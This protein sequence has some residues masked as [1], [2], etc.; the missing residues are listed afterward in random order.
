[1]TWWRVEGGAIDPE[2][3][4]GISAAVADPLWLLARQWQVGEFRGEDAASPVLIEGTVEAAPITE[5]WVERGKQRRTVGRGANPWPL[6]TLVEHEPIAEGP[7]SA[8]VRLEGGAE[9][10]RRLV[11]ARAPVDPVLD[12]FREAYAFIDELDAE[13]D[14]VGHAR[15]VLL[16]RRV[17]DASRVADAVQSA[18]GD[19]ARLAQLTG[20]DETLAD[21]LAAVVTD[22]LADESAMFCDVAPDTLTA[23]VTPRL[24]Y[25]FGVSAAISSG[26]IE[27]EAEEYPGGRLD[28][29]HFDVRPAP[30]AP[31][32]PKSGRDPVGGRIPVPGEIEDPKPVPGLESKA[33]SSLAS[34]LTFAGMPASRWWEFEDHDVDFGDLA[35]GPDDLARS[36]IAAYSMVAGDDWFVVPCTLTAGSLAQVRTMRVLDDFG[37]S[38][39]ISATAVGDQQSGSRPWRFFELSGDPG[40]GRDEAPMLFLLPVLAGVE[41][42][43]PLESVAFRRDEMANLAWAI[44]Q[45]VE[46]EAGRAVDREAG[47]PAVNGHKVEGD[48]W[49][50]RLST[51][52]PDH[53]VPLVPVRINGQ[54]PQIA[55]RR[56]RIA[57][58]GDEQPA[59]GRILEPEHPF[60]M[61][62]EEIPFGGVRV[63][64]RYQVARG[65]DG[66][67]RAWVGR[68]KAPAGGP[69]R[70]TP[71]RFDELI[72]W[73]R[74][75]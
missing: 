29:F 42:G 75:A 71:L 12:G 5:Y 2:L 8:R 21:A 45:R 56:G 33:L 28:W 15:L 69:L 63:T 36:V 43:R 38:T 19:P 35:G 54:N 11:A 60:V 55:L 27:L 64:R 17:P 53:W 3:T 26:T 51:D 49:R 68:H 16:A 50:Y 40:P 32:D 52:V 20:L 70:R 41:Q 66:K 30:D 13:L 22:W 47:G 48:D 44:E 9:L 58:E 4:E 65:A 31:K 67:V 18:G 34:P 74:R 25:S 61:H 62:E 59:K 23:W 14:P 72:G 6:E 46:S 57:L 7:A 37:S 39:P 1:M 73:A 24:E 10:F